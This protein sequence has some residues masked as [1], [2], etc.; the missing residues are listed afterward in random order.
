VMIVAA[1]AGPIGAMFSRNRD[2]YRALPNL[3]RGFNRGKRRGAVVLR[4][5]DAN[6]RSAVTSSLAAADVA[7]IDL[8]D[9]SDHVAWEIAEA[10]KACTTSGLVFICRDGVKLSDAAKAALRGVGREPKNVAHYPA[11]RGGDEK[12]F[13]RDLRESIYNAADLRQA[14]S[15]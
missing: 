5:S 11:R 10:S 14:R 15:A 8:S 1:L 4:I 7:I 9:V 12:R 13:A 3:L 6:W 2:D